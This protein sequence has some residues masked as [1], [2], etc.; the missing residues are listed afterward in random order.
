[1]NTIPKSIS[2]TLSEEEVGQIRLE[3][4]IQQRK[5]M[6]YMSSLIIQQKDSITLLKQ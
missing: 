1:M 2:A 6:E 3:R 5:R 4:V